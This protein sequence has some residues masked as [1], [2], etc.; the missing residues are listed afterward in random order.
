M[1]EPRATHTSRDE[2]HSAV[3]I[4][5]LEPSDVELARNT[6]VMVG[7]VFDDEDLPPL[8][9]AFVAQ[10]LA[11]ED[12]W[13]YAAT[14]EGDPVGGMT[15]HVLPLT[16]TEST[17]LMIYDIA[18]RADWQRRGVGASLLRRLRLD[19]A[20][21]GIRELWV[22]AENEDTHAIEF[23]RRTGGHPQAVTIYTYSAEAQ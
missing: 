17:E 13:L 6:L 2:A 18:V 3:D 10:L 12:L 14:A 8:R 23:Y 11:R 20:A 5:R 7:E 21:A 15:V 1:T 22:P 19:A 9:D 4:V 16:R